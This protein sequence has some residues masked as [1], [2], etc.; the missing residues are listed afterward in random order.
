VEQRKAGVMVVSWSRSRDVWVDPN[1]PAA[2]DVETWCFVRVGDPHYPALTPVAKRCAE[3]GQVFVRRGGVTEPFGRLVRHWALA[4]EL[5]RGSDAAVVAKVRGLVLLASEDR[6]ALAVAGSWRLAAVILN[7]HGWAGAEAAECAVATGTDP[8]IARRRGPV[9]ATLYAAGILV[10]GEDLELWLSPAS[11]S[12]VDA[13]VLAIQAG[14]S[15]SEVT[16]EMLADVP[17]LRVMAAL[18]GHD[19]GAR[20]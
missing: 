2:V 14:L 8:V 7:Q 3:Y 19:G 4:S 20:S 17:S 16:D 5:D 10:T 15:A 11:S 18:N 6:S 12:G 13:V 9:L 1:A